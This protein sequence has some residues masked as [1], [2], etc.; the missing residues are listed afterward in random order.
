MENDA[1]KIDLINNLI[2]DSFIRKYNL[3]FLLRR[4]GRMEISFGINL[5][6][7]E[8]YYPYA[9][10]MPYVR[11]KRNPLQNLLDVSYVNFSKEDLSERADSNMDYS[12]K[13]FLNFEEDN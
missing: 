3:D 2:N 5:E 13:G 10:N 8:F 7:G 9:E 12:I 1:E 11:L 4:T 6:N